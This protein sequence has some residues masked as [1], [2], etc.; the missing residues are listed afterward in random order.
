VGIGVVSHRNGKLVT[1]TFSNL[2][3]GTVMESPVLVNSSYSAGSFSAAFQTQS[4]VSYT[5]QF[6]DDLD[7]SMWNTLTTVTGD[8]ALMSFTDPG[9]ISPTGNRF[10]RVSV[11]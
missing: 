4:G 10:Y 7:A 1:G 6:K 3:L 11:P 9:P 2:Q 5:V 8:G